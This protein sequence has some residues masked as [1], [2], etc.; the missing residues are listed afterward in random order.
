MYQPIDNE[1]RRERGRKNISKNNGDKY[2][3]L[4]MKLNSQQ[5]KQTP[6][7]KTQNRS[8]LSHI[9]IKWSKPKQKR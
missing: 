6:S 3:K 7:R 5:T 4:D 1:T 8:R 2:P 9:N